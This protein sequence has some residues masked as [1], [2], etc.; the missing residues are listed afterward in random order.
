MDRGKPQ[1]SA[2]RPESPVFWPRLV[3]G[4]LVVSAVL[5]VLL[6]QRGG[7]MFWPDESRFDVARDA[8]ARFAA[9]ETAAAWRLLLG[10]ADHL[11][12]KLIGLFPAAMEYRLGTPRDVVPALFFANLSVVNILLVWRIARA[13]GA[14]GR[15]AAVAAGCMAA[16]ATN[17]Y[18]A[19]HL[20]PYDLAMTFG[21]LALWAGWTGVGGWGRS[22]FCGVSGG[23]A[24]LSYNGSWLFGAV[25]LTGHV[26]AG[27]P[28]WRR[29]GA[30]ALAAGG[31]LALPI[32]AAVAGARAV[33]V[34]LVASFVG[35]SQTINQGDFGRG[36]RLLL[37][38]F[39]AA[40]GLNAVL[41]GLA[42][43]AVTLGV[44]LARRWTRGAAWLAGATAVVAGLVLLSDVWPKFVIYGR[45]ARFVLPFVCLATAYGI[46]RW[47][48]LGGRAA[49][50]ALVLVA[51]GAGQA[52]AN[53][54]APLQQVFPR[55]FY[56]EAA[57]RQEQLRAQ[58]EA[59]QLAI[60]YSGA[61][62]NR[63]TIL[64]G[65]PDHEVI[66]AAA[67]PIQYEPY[68][69][70]GYSEAERRLLGT[71]DVRMRLIAVNRA[72][73]D[74][75]AELRRPYPG[76]VR[77]TVRLPEPP[78]VPGAPE[79]LLVT[80]ETGRGDFLYLVYQ[81]DASIRIGY[82]HWGAGGKVSDPV[83]VDLTRPIEITLSM[84]SLHGPSASEPTVPWRLDPK[85]WLYVEVNG[86]VVW[87]HA[88]EFH[89]AAPG[90][91]SLLNNYIGGSTAGIKFTGRVLKVESLLS[92][93]FADQPAEV[94]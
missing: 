67:N 46:E 18:Y 78:H 69:F 77:L 61:L 66:L 37:E 40:E 41:A 44:C 81:G 65:L 70:E 39:W 11:F 52:V 90:S 64:S 74:Y 17:F 8:V 85:R 15:E 53:L 6:V 48:S 62:V 49:T 32:A 22:L 35:F 19:R 38:Y 82:D 30:R 60:I 88:A 94:R 51:L 93:P 56:H 59:R 23:L 25:V 42:F 45:T 14:G 28:G 75:P 21:L 73:F 33:G 24:F 80:G 79:P 92:P 27:M 10:G 43:V 87:S 89:P 7:Q 50:S 58:G 5:R 13:A 29:A 4:V 83:P 2:A 54:W 57:R 84:G 34:D 1:L 72:R 68:L 36:W 26:L 3:L 16:A 31:G 91:I 71:A 20:F 12:F 63:A 86:R 76:V 9:G 55:Q 47:W